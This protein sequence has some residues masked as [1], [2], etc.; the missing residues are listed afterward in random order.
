MNERPAALLQAG[1]PPRRPVGYGLENYTSP[2]LTDDQKQAQRRQ[3]LQKIKRSATNQS[4]T[5]T[6]FSVRN[7]DRQTIATDL[8]SVSQIAV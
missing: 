8:C 1:Q 4:A 5:T 6:C 2:P 3:L 7:V